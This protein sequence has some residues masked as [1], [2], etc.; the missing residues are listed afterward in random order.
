MVTVLCFARVK[1]LAITELTIATLFALVFVMRHQMSCCRFLYFFSGPTCGFLKKPQNP[2]QLCCFITIAPVQYQS[3]SIIALIV[4]WEWPGDYGFLL[5]AQKTFCFK[6]RGIILVESSQ[7]R[8]LS[9]WLGEGGWS[10]RAVAQ[11]R[12][13]VSKLGLKGLSDHYSRE[14]AVKAA[15]QGLLV[16]WIKG[17]LSQNIY[18]NRESWTTALSLTE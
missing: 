17:L 5:C 13:R 4:S 14:I 10:G 6:P 8:W 3:S 7:I 1:Y 2:Q 11:Q 18:W 12:P 15:R 9:I 16:G